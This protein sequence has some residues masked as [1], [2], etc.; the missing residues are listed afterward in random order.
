VLLLVDNA[1]GAYLKFLSSSAHP[2]DLGATMCCDSAHKTLPVLTGGGYLHVSNSA[3]A[4]FKQNAKNAMALFGSTSPS[5]L[6]L[7]SLDAVN[8]YIFDGYKDKLKNTVSLIEKL[9]DT[10]KDFGYSLIGNEALKL[11]LEV[12]KFGYVGNDFNEILKENNIYVEFYDPDYVVFMLTPDTSKQDIERLQNA[13]LS[14]ER[15]APIDK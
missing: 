9:K 8:K 2:I 4:F 6:I 10:L 1:H 15:K 14:I 13:L 5:Y 12:K 7:Q 3:P 11:T